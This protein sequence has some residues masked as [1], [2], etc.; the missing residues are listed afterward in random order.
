KESNRLSRTV[1]LL[2]FFGIKATLLDDGIEVEGNQEP[3]KPDQPVPTF[4]DH[5]LFMTAV[6]LAA[7]T[8]GS[9]IGHTLHQVADESFLQRLQSA[10]IGIEATTTPSLLD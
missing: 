7:K 10:G 5:R 3:K 1:E 6:L 4:G 9:V 8:G 2:S